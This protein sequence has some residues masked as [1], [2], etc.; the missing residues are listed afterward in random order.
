MVRHTHQVGRVKGMGQI[1]WEGES[2]FISE[3]VRGELV[4]LAETDRG[5]GWSGS[6]TWNS[7]ASIARRGVLPRHGTAGGSADGDGGASLWKYRSHR[8][9]RT[10]PT[11]AWKAR[12]RTRA[13]HIP[14]ANL[15]LE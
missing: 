12:G 9:H 5:I 6:W 1:K 4:G 13:S 15:L 10:W 2:V 14:Q 8:P 7:G 3:A 11:G